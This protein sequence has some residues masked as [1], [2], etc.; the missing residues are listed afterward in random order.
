MMEEAIIE[1]W[2]LSLIVYSIYTCLIL[3]ILGDIREELR[4]IRKEAQP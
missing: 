2:I 1:L 4:K 3:N